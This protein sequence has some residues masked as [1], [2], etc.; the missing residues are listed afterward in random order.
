MF[1]VFR[2]F[3]KITPFAP[4]S[5]IYPQTPVV[6]FLQEKGGYNRFWGY[7]EGYI[8]SNFQIY[9]KTYSP[10]GYDAIHIKEYTEFLTTS[11]D[12]S[13]PSFL[14]RPDANIA[15]GFGPH[16]LRDNHYRQKFSI[17]LE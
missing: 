16:E 13:I 4:V 3:H 1:D 10:E 8:N 5:Y 2:F 6:T 14:P 15:S 11:K 9:D 7:G 12:G 17:F